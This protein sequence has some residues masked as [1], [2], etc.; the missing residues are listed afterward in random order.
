MHCVKHF[1]FELV[2]ATRNGEALRDRRALLQDAGKLCRRPNS[3]KVDAAIVKAIGIDETSDQAE[4]KIV[5]VDRV[6]RKKRP[7]RF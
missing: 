2:I 5:T 6:C 3:R 7:A 4:R 1:E